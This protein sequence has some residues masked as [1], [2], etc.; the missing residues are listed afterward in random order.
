MIYKVSKSTNGCQNED[1]TKLWG[2][3]ASWSW[4]HASACGPWAARWVS[5]ILAARDVR[6]ACLRKLATSLLATPSRPH[7][8]ESATH[9]QRAMVFAQVCLTCW[10]HWMPRQVSLP[11]R[12]AFL[13][14]WWCWPALC[15][16][17]SSACCC[18]SST[19]SLCC[20]PLRMSLMS[21]WQ[22]FCHT[23]SSVRSEVENGAT[24]IQWEVR[25]MT[26]AGTHLFKIQSSCICLVGMCAYPQYNLLIPSNFFQKRD[27]CREFS[28]VFCS[29]QATWCSVCWNSGRGEVLRLKGFWD[30]NACKSTC[31]GLVCWEWSF[32]C[33]AC[34]L[35]SNYPQ[36]HPIRPS[37]NGT[38]I[39]C[40]AGIWVG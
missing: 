8:M 12:T 7:P 22:T 38:P 6:W 25:V 34:E 14:S 31:A 17:S 10:S 20:C 33:E 1:K 23:S 40:H 3:L 36:S 9:C 37:C 5:W 15:C 4:L 19:T 39:I 27:M 26:L 30:L 11:R 16:C 28:D 35:F 32:S 13:P 29:V 18:C 2:L 21:M 24:L